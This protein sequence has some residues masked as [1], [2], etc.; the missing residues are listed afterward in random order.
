MAH[1]SSVPEPPHVRFREVRKRFGSLEVLRGVTFDVRHGEVHAVLGENGAGKTTLMRILYGLESADSGYVEVGGRPLAAHGPRQAIAAGVGLV[2]QHG[3]VVAGLSVLENLVLGAEPARYGVVARSQALRRAEQAAFTLGVELAWDAP[4]ESLTVGQ[5]QQLEM[6][7]ILD[8]GSR[9]L[10]FDEPTA[11]LT[12]GEVVQFIT[13]VRSLVARGHTVIFITHKLR[14]VMAV[15]DTVTVLRQGMVAATLPRAEVS[16]EDLARR[17]IG[18]LPAAAIDPCRPE[19]GAPLLELRG[20]CAPAREP[21]GP[22]LTGIDLTART[23]EIVGV[24]G[25]DGNGQEELMQVIVGTRAPTAGGITLC[26]TRVTG[27]GVRRRRALGLAFVPA[28]RVHEG[29]DVVASVEDNTVAPRLGLA[30]FQRGGVLRPGA[31]RRFAREVLHLAEVRAHPTTTAR[32]LSG[33]NMQRLVVGR[34]SLRTPRVLVAAYPTRGVDL[35]GVEFI[36]G[37]LRQ[38]RD[39]GAA[40]LVVSNDLDELFRLC[41][42]VYVLHRGRLVGGVRPEAA[43]ATDVGLMMTG[44]R[45]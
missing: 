5:R 45:A 15:A 12:E 21:G 36:Y 39:E 29:L 13:V 22:A 11:I 34:E 30:E 8:R 20:V 25:V 32:H 23:G 33:G 16:L 40:V 27:L 37:R 24:A 42:Y 1:E 18:D 38:M 14:E 3:Q 31:I 10:V 4:A 43:D 9:L 35:H 7:R 28:D 19:P 41:T 26:D 6:L 44:A 17:M 2:P